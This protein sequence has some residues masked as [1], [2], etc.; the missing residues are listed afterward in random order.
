MLIES[1]LKLKTLEEKIK[2]FENEKKIFKKAQD[3]NIL[4]NNQKYKDKINN[5]NMEI[6]KL[7]T[8][9]K[10]KEEEILL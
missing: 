1:K 2:N 5:L 6:N 3:R 4:E 9:I 10:T 7:K 8:E